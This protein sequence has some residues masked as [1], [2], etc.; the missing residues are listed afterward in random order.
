MQSEIHHHVHNSP[1][2]NTIFGQSVLVST[3]ELHT[4]YIHEP[5]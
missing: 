5:K 1:S 4:N 3:F 2:L